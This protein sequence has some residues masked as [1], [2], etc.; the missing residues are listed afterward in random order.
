MN[1]ILSTLLQWSTNNPQWLGTIIFF[2]ALL[3]CLALVGILLPG[4]VLL[5]GLAVIAGN[6][7]LDLSSALLLAWIGGLCGDLLSYG[8]GR[9]LQHKVPQLPFLRRNPHWLINAELHFTRYGALSLLV[10][11]FIGPLRPV[12]PLVAGMLSMPITRFT[13]VSLFAAAG[14][15]VAYIMPGWLVGAALE[16]SPPQ[17]FWTQALLII[18]S[19]AGVALLSTIACLR[20]WRNSSLVSAAALALTLCGLMLS[21]PWFN[22]FDNYL[23][24]LSQLLRTAWLDQTM[25]LITRLGD[26]K[27]QLAVGFILCASLLF[28]KQLQALL[29]SFMALTATVSSN[30]LLKHVFARARPDVLL[31]PLQSF[32]FPSGHS[33]SGAAFFLVLGILAG[34]GQPKR[35][36]IFWLCLAFVPIV[37]I[38]LSRVY[39][40]AHWP[41]D[42]L[43][44]VLLGSLVCACSLAL[45]QHNQAIPALPKSYWKASFALL[46]I[47]FAFLISFNLTQSLQLYAY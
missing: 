17:G 31:E 5:F 36:R 43:A 18:C 22:I 8:L 30:Y 39:L 1:E 16:L 40:T 38:A 15:A 33:A 44:G 27:T 32:S 9:R 10:G 23:H 20:D 42:I 7:T 6:N 46:T 26:V 24:E 28:F 11:R 25:V 37:S 35:W 12:L 13:L 21:W 4:V 47:S 2:T 34:R 29:F 45:S 41:T 14:W 3:E 19:L